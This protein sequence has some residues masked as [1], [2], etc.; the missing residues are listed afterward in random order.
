[1]KRVLPPTLVLCCLVSM[2]LLHW[3][4]PIAGVLPTPF[5]LLG[6][7]PLVPGLV[8]NLAADRA[9]KIAGTNVKTF[10][11][12]DTLITYGLFRYSRNP[13]Y[14]GFVFI[15]AGA[16]MLLGSASPFLGVAA[17]FLVSNCYYIPFEEHMLAEKFGGRF[18][19]Y[20]SKTRRWI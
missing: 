17:F 10:N 15:L 11:E 14:L 12:P 9:F 16:W 19:A 1:M 2:M 4:L 7:L 8:L 3:L 13:M 20:A 5:N 6:L 18:E